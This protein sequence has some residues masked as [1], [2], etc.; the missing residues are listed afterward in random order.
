MD[1][2]K[3]LIFGQARYLMLWTTCVGYFS[4]IDS[5][6][7]LEGGGGKLEIRDYRKVSCSEPF[8]RPLTRYM[9]EGPESQMT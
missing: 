7:V 1:M 9:G 4:Q 2:K 5:Y 8:A 6:S 3:S